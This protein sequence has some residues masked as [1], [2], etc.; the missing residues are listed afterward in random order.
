M[1]SKGSIDEP[2]R[3]PDSSEKAYI[4]AVSRGTNRVASIE[5]SSALYF[6]LDGHQK[7]VIRS[8]FSECS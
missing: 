4:E 7:G 5:V 3:L 8:D 1:I 2:Y 6:P